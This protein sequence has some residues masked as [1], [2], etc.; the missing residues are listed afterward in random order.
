MSSMKH[1]KEMKAMAEQMVVIEEQI[2]ET[3]RMMQDYKVWVSSG[4]PEKFIAIGS[5]NA[6]RVEDAGR[7]DVDFVVGC[8][9]G[10]R[11]KQQTTSTD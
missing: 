3:R 6:G 7:L 2:V 1:T 4:N 10:K 9:I 5:P 8:A 11:K